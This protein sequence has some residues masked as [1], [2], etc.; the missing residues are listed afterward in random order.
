MSVVSK[1]AN[2]AASNAP[3]DG[4]D[5]LPVSSKMK[6]VASQNIAVDAIKARF[7]LTIVLNNN[8]SII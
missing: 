5:R 7:I 8:I 1:P 2:L 6:K 3:S 4:N